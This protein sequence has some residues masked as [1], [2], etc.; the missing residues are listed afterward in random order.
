MEKTNSL[1][2]A[3]L[4]Q[5]DFDALID[6]SLENALPIIVGKCL[7][8]KTSPAV[9]YTISVTPVPVAD[10]VRNVNVLMHIKAV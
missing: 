8:D 6:C 7:V 2:D 9:F 5:Q 4:L 10:I 1:E 3:H